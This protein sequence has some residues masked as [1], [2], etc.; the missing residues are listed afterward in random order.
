MSVD[1]MTTMLAVRARFNP[2]RETFDPDTQFVDRVLDWIV[3]ERADGR[4]TS[5]NP[6]SLVSYDFGPSAA[7]VGPSVKLRNGE[8]V[9]GAVHLCNPS[10]QRANLEVSTSVLVTMEAHQETLAQRQH[11]ARTSVTFNPATGRAQ[12]RLACLTLP[13]P[14]EITLASVS[15]ANWAGAG[16]SR[17]P[18]AL[19]IFHSGITQD[20]G[21]GPVF[22]ED[23]VPRANMRIYYRNAIYLFLKFEVGLGAS[24]TYRLT[25]NDRHVRVTDAATNDSV[26]VTG[27]YERPRGVGDGSACERAVAAATEILDQQGVPTHISCMHCSSR[28]GPNEECAAGPLSLRHR[29]VVAA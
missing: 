22:F 2:A 21:V 13:T 3:S 11:L 25:A 24:R 19:N 10:L 29:H 9:Q 23:G 16:L 14:V 20:A 15:G 27:I 17:L 12:I 4:L 8:V 6:V 26:L 5:G 18:A 1:D 28:R 7:P